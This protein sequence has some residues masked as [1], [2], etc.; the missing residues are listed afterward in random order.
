[1]IVSNPESENSTLFGQIAGKLFARAET[2]ET[3]EPREKDLAALFFGSD[4]STGVFG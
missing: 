4:L 2:L 1:M 3:P